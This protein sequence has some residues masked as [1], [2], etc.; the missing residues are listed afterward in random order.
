MNYKNLV[1][2]NLK[3]LIYEKVKLNRSSND[4]HILHKD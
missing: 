3:P 1:F 2:N 4:H